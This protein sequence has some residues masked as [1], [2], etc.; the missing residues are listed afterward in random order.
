MCFPCRQDPPICRKAQVSWA[1]APLGDFPLFFICFT[2]S[3]NVF[4]NERC[5]PDSLP[6]C[7]ADAVSSGKVLLTLLPFSVGLMVASG[8]LS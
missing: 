7:V 6:D 2:I 5:Q 4:S 8:K 3:P 1:R